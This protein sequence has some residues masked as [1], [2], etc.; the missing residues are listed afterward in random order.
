MVQSIVEHHQP[1]EAVAQKE[2]RPAVL[3]GSDDGDE[4]PKVV[5][6]PSPAVDVPPGTGGAAIAA[7]I[8]RVNRQSAGN[9]VV[10]QH[11]VEAAV[12]ADSMHVDQYGAGGDD[13]TPLLT[14]QFEPVSRP[15]GR[16]EVGSNRLGLRHRWSLA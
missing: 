3:L 16:F 4:S 14:E 15:K 13:R 5:S 10:G 6:Q 9:E 7:H 11:G 8:E 2:H 12:V 1:A